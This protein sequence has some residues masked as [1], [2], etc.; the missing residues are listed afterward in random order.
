MENE[1]LG[2]LACGLPKNQ[3]VHRDI[4]LWPHPPLSLDLL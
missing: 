2:H 1:F 3:G 4:M